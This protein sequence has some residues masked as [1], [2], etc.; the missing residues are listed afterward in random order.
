LKEEIKFLE[1]KSGKKLNWDR[2]KEICQESNRM[3]DQALDWL[4]WRKAIPCPQTAKM[5]STMYIL[6]QD[7]SGSKGATWVASEF[8][9][10]AKER[11]Q[12]GKSAAPGG[13]KIRAIWFGSPPWYNISFYDWMENEL[14]M[15]VPVDMFSY[16]VPEMYVDTST[17][18]TLLHDLARKQI[19]MPMG[20]HF[21]GAPEYFVDD[22]VRAAADYKADCALI[23]GHVSCKHAWGVLGLLKEALREADIPALAFEFDLFDPR[24]TTIETLQQEFKRFA[25]D[26]VLP[27]IGK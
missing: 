3:I 15:V 10:D 16:V 5:L 7:G 23:A 20:R 21:T 13:E 27:R 8:A 12:A 22:L 14:G 19:Y 26:I 6:L 11:V 17:T 18:E 1:E 24:V 9:A 25:E 2:L 4:E